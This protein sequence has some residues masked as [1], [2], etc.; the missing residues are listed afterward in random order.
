MKYLHKNYHYRAT[1]C[2]SYSIK[3]WCNE[4]L[5]EYLN[6]KILTSCCIYKVFYQHTNFLVGLL[7]TNERIN[8]HQI[9]QYFYHQNF[10]LHASWCR[11]ENVLLSCLSIPM[12]IIAGGETTMKSHDLI[13]TMHTFAGIIHYHYSQSK[14]PSFGLLFTS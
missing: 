1:T 2:S 5:T 13:T 6:S 9:H 8:L 12:Y 11:N 3:F 4:I 14:S 10:M 7:V